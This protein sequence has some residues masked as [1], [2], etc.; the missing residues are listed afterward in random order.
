MGIL[1]AMTPRNDRPSNPKN[2]PDESLPP[3]VPVDVN[4]GN[5]GDA[6][7]SDAV[8]QPQQGRDGLKEILEKSKRRI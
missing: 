2:L 1:L 5:S 8:D 7:E 3:H 4:I 6:G